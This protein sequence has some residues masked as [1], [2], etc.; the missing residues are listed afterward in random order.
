MN[1]FGARLRIALLSGRRANVRGFGAVAPRRSDGYEFAELRGYVEGDD[2]RR[3]DWAATARAGNLQ[4]RVMLEDTALVLAAAIDPSPSMQVGRTRSNYEVACAAAAAWYDAASDDDRC[5][6]VGNGL[7]SL[8]SLRGRAA[9]HV[10]SHAREPAADSFPRALDVALAILPRAARLL[11]ASDF[12]ALAD[13]RE[14]L[15]SCAARFEVTALCIADPW[16]MGM[17]LGGFVRFRDARS[18]DVARIYIDRAARARY[19]EAVSRREAAV[20]RELRDLGIRGFVVGAEE[21]P[22]AAFA[23]EFGFGTPA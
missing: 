8:P 17:P 4:T 10:C 21:A 13:L 14:R 2:P 22:E 1:A 5:L 18:G 3:I 20:V 15:R 19:V 12:F 9:A 7:L 23:R 16:R 11:I 6:R